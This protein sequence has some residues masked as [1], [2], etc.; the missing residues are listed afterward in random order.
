MFG[1]H[2]G[3]VQVNEIKRWEHARVP[4]YG[5]HPGWL[6]TPNISKAMSSSQA[7]YELQETMFL[8]Q[9]FLEDAILNTWKSQ[10]DIYCFSEFRLQLLESSQGAKKTRCFCRQFE[11]SGMSE[12]KKTQKWHI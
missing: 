3:Q 8:W 11:Q 6:Q 5:L 4:V 2:E 7:N 1:S 9:W 10:T 12:E